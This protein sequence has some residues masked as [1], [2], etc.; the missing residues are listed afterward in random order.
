MRK[1]KRDK[2]TD[3]ARTAISEKSAGVSITTLMLS[4]VIICALAATAFQRNSIYKDFIT[5]WGNITKTS[6]NKRRAHENYGQ[7]LST[8]GRLEEAL[9]EF[10]TV[11]AL[12]DDGSVPL[13]DLYREIGVVYFRMNRMD[14][15][16]SAWQTGLRHARNDAS[17][18]NNL[19]IALLQ[20][21]R[22]EEAAS[23]A[24]TALTSDP[25]LPQ[26][27][28]TMGQVLMFK[29]DYEN[30]LQYFLKA[31]EQ[32]PDVPARYWN[33]ALALEQAG[34][35][36]MAMKYVSKY[37]TLEQDGAGRQRAIGFMEHLNKMMV[38]QQ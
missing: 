13:R 10:N 20:T 28:N 24:Q 19:S 36:D 4:L 22:Y 26:A 14:D 23:L 16:I 3:T 1:T 29:K 21:G 2:T 35:Y 25:N 27:L 31:I 30:A 37:A 5:L 17:L 32:Q 9:R 18:L 7:A 11:L 34:K 12:K 38:R 8:V 6:P 15:A 33:V